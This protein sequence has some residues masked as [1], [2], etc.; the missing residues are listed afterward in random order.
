MKLSLMN[1]FLSL[2]I[3]IVSHQKE[4]NK[5]ADIVRKPNGTYLIR[6]L[7]GKDDRGKPVTVSRMIKLFFVSNTHTPKSFTS[8]PDPSKAHT[9][10]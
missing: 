1:R 6:I 4:E 9:G 3:K 7:A 5:M 2:Q 10:S 8:P